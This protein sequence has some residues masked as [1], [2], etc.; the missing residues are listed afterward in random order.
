MKKLFGFLVLFIVISCSK[1]E[2]SNENPA[3]TQV[4]IVSV[5][6]KVATFMSTYN[7]PGASLAISQNG[8]LVYVKGYG[9]ANSTTG[10]NVTTNHRFRLASLS[11]TYTGIAIMKLI[12]D[13]QFTL[14]TNVFWSNWNP[15][16]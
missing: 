4:D 16:K 12:Q 5:D 2:S 9:K 6:S 1:N 8:K 10:E 3:T 11:K 7:I 15:R 13:G 14:D